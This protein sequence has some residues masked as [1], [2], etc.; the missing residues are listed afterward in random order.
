MKKVVMIVA[1]LVVAV[2]ILA[3]NGLG[4]VE[5]EV[6]FFHFGQRVVGILTLPEPVYDEVPALLMLHG[7]TGQK[8]EMGVAGTEEA[9]FEMAARIFAEHGIAS[10]RID[11]R[12]SGDSDGLWKDTTFSSQISDAQ[13]AISYLETIPQVDPTRIGVLGFSQGGLVAACTAARDWRIETAI[14]WAPVASPAFTYSQIL[15]AETV[16]EALTIDPDE[17]IDATLPWGAVTTLKKPF[18]N[19]LFLIDPVAEIASYFGP[20]MVVIGLNDDVVFP[21]PHAGQIFIDNHFG[22]RKFVQLETDHMFGIFSGPEI[23]VE[24]VYEAID[25]VYLTMP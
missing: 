5:R 17:T 24:A 25:W 8:N 21:Q 20:L 22:W 13:A 19:E 4:A 18:Y 16:L 9:M 12:G 1:V 2:G 7:F 14:L 6:S 3:A 23:L 11:F 10:L 15:G